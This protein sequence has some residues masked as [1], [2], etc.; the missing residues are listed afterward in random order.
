M[1][2]DANTPFPGVAE[3]LRV[4]V[5][6][7]IDL[8]RPAERIQPERFH[9]MLRDREAAAR[10]EFDLWF[11]GKEMSAANDH[12]ARQRSSASKMRSQM[13]RQMPVRESIAQNVSRSS[14]L[15]NQPRRLKLGLPDSYRHVV[16]T[17]ICSRDCGFQSHQKC[18]DG[19]PSS[20]S[21]AAYNP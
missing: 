17:S 15:M 3:R 14:S 7:V 19:I 13:S 12:V 5:E 8:R 21:L 16:V 6:T 18:M 1:R 10:S 2:A 9:V 20:F 4:L 11:V